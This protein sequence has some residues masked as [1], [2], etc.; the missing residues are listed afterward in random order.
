MDRYNDRAA[1]LA[2]AERTR[3][4]DLSDLRSRFLSE[5]PHGSSDTLRILDLGCGP[6]RD[7]RA[8][9]AAGYDVE[10]M[11]PSPA[12]VRL[13]RNYAQA[14]VRT[15]RAQDLDATE[16]YDGIWACASL[17]HVPLTDLPDVFSRIAR[18]LRAD[19]ILYASFKHGPTER[20]VDGCHFTDMNETRLLDC[21]SHAVEL[22]VVDIWETVDVRPERSGETWLN[23]LLRR[24]SG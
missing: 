9:K 24:G 19:G 3:Q 10:G 12:M 18:A 15:R 2:Y 23:V 13:A 22:Q 17:L 16:A 7:T 11:D 5:L 1:A 6:G 21:I 20:T 8:F 14:P 4:L